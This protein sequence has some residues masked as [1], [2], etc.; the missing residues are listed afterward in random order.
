MSRY[1]GRTKWVVFILVF[2][3][4][5]LAVAGGW[6]SFM[7]LAREA[8]HEI[9]LRLDAI[10]ELKLGELS[11]WLSERRKDVLFNATHPMFTAKV[12]RWLLQ[13]DN[14]D[15]DSIRD[16][17]ESLIKTHDYTSAA[18]LDLKG[19]IRLLVGNQTPDAEIR[20]QALK[21]LQAGAES[22]L[23]DL[24]QY[25]QEY[26]ILMG[27]AAPI[28]SDDQSIKAV[29][30]LTIN[31]AT[32]LYKIL[33]DWPLENTE[34]KIILAGLEGNKII[35]L[36]SYHFGAP[37][38]TQ[39]IFNT[40]SLFDVHDPDG[41][42]TLYRTRSVP[43]TPWVILVAEDRDEID[44]ITQRLI[45]EISTI[46]FFLALSLFF[47]MYYFWR[48][49]VWWTE[50]RELAQ[51]LALQKANDHFRGT[52][53][54]AAV[55]I[56]HTDLEGRI[57]QI[58]RKLCSLLGYQPETLL[59]TTF[60]ALY[61]AEKRVSNLDYLQF[62]IKGKIANFEMDKPYLCKHGKVLWFHITIS[63]FASKKG[64][65]DYLIW[66]FEDMTQRHHAEQSLMASKSLYK[67]LF[68]HSPIA[69]I[70]SDYSMA[71]KVVNEL[72]D[73]GTEDIVAYLLENHDRLRNMAALV[74]ITNL[75]QEAIHLLELQPDQDPPSSLADYFNAE[76]FDVFARQFDAL[77]A[78]RP[79]IEHEMPL[80]TA[81]GRKIFISTHL[82]ILPGQDSEY[83]RVLLSLLD[84]TERK[85]ME[86]KLLS[87][88][89]ELESRV[90]TRTAE[91]MAK[92]A[93]LQDTYTQQQAIFE[94]VSSGICLVKNMMIV[95]CNKRLGEIYGYNPEDMINR[96]VSDLYPDSNSYLSSRDYYEYI[97]DGMTVRFDLPQIR[98]D[99]T[100]LYCRVSGRL[101]DNEAPDKGSVWV[102]EDITQEHRMTEDL[103]IAKNAAEAANRSKSSFLAN[104]SH[105]IRTPLNAILGYTHL[106]QNDLSDWRQRD[107]LRRIADAAQHLLDII[108][109]VLDIS[110]I[111]AGKFTLDT[112]EFRLDEMLGKV[113]NLI[114]EKAD[115]KGLEIISD[116]E[117]LLSSS[118]LGDSLRLGQIMLNLLSNAAKFT[119]EGLIRVYVT[120]E[121]EDAEGRSI[122]RFEVSDTGV[123]IDSDVQSRLFRPFEQAD[124]SITRQFGGT[125]LGLAISRRLV[126]MMGGEIG[127]ESAPGQGSSFWFTVPLTRGDATASLESLYAA[128]QLRCLVVDDQPEV[129]AILVRMLNYLGIE[130]DYAESGESA[131]ERVSAA[132]AAGAGY[133]LAILDCRM[134]GL[135]GPETVSR[136]KRLGLLSP[137][138][139][140][141]MLT[142]LSDY[143]RPTTAPDHPTE[144]FLVKPVTLTH[145]QKCLSGVMNITVEADTVSTSPVES[146]E[147]ALLH[148]T[149]EGIVKTVPLK[150]G[151]RWPQSFVAELQALLAEDNI[152]AS[153]VFHEHEKF[154]MDFMG[155]QAGEFAYFIKTFEFDHALDILQSV[156]EKRK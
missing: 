63:L 23:I 92:T 70:E 10:A 129:C 127:V 25:P 3:A 142:P 102:M 134:P 42:P 114:A 91:L 82:A 4:A 52:F 78:A 77:M 13:H 108:S 86:S 120:V 136:I 61:L 65:S 1:K 101:L 31:P 97:E 83:Q 121:G 106:L 145:L 59:G 56:A 21:R 28:R 152:E 15:R 87:M 5:I 46:T 88:N 67:A 117:P 17:L 18:L 11:G 140:I 41:V 53:E 80:I 81:Q 27:Y 75:N 151:T 154:F 90:Y 60:Q 124:D 7:Q 146:G 135:S 149:E 9:N 66:V 156:C 139:C 109:D 103:V 16:A 35:N 116:V 93:E 113:Y 22:V 29:L 112:V 153:T 38:N 74:R 44:R 57:T 47:F 26:T 104:M 105:E 45:F 98:K 72:E 69:L 84:I 122:L 138:K 8:R 79:V 12:N 34:G 43:D 130:A 96:P 85:Q 73:R 89:A 40:H 95:R 125:G 150:G 155:D 137:P 144:A 100:L 49:Q 99:G 76:S 119:H 147:P 62:L 68:E 126:Q 20:I 55:G 64:D 33:D 37:L 19:Q 54:Q 32:H 148:E 30:L 111:E 58:N 94:S 50:R 71:M 48:R 123:G 51:E 118:F 24:Y 110:K 115:A 39:N 2:M 107:N 14:R 128:L 141:F 36:T 131:L 6:M 143:S 132:Y 133:D